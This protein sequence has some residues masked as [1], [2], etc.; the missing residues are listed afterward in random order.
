MSTHKQEPS[1]VT[2]QERDQ[3][4]RL[5]CGITVKGIYHFS[6]ALYLDAFIE[7]SETLDY[8]QR[9]FQWHCSQASITNTNINIVCHK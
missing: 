1:K 7:A 2:S 8:Q 5:L 6:L 4:Q 9:Y 3:F